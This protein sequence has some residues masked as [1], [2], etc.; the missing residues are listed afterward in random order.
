MNIAPQPDAATPAT[1]ARGDRA[2]PLIAALVLAAVACQLCIS[3]PTPAL[4]DIAA[5]L[6]TTTDVIGLA[7]ALFFLLGGLLSVIMAACSDYGNARTLMAVSLVLAVAGSLVAAA[8][9]GV[10]V[11]VVGRALQATA[12][13]VFPVALRVL[14]QTL[15]PGLFGRAMGIITAANGGIVGLD[16]L[17]SGWLTDTYGYRSVFLVMAG[18]GAV[19]TVVVLR[20]V[21]DLRQRP[22][23]RLDWAG[24]VV[25]SLGLACVELGIGM[26]GRAHAGVTLGTV[27]AGVVLFAVF[28]R[29]ESGRAHALLPPSYLKSRQAWPVLVTSV[30]ACAGML[31][32]VNYVVPVFSRSADA[33]YGLSATFAALLFIVP[34]C[35]VNVVFAPV[36]GA[37]APRVGW[38]RMLR[39]SMAVTV[40][41]LV[42]LGLGLG[43]RWVTFT[44]VVLVGF[45]LA[46]A[47]TPLNGLSAILAAPNN[48]GLLP[49][50]NAAAYGV[51]SSLGIAMASQLLGDR[52]GAADYHHAVWVAAGVVALGFLSSLLITG[53]AGEHGEKV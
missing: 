2:T 34:V 51:G 30:L 24:L 8:A 1:A 27:A 52:A 22:A 15:P 47:L 29:V 18:F 38:R 32:T 12:T 35:L 16:G 21:P 39:L 9:P 46:G 36:A 23:G 7:Q 25:L 13:A 45:G 20:V 6:H 3:M 44:L 42:C 41:V 40:P 26:A 14:R 17:L 53:R 5:T 33:G 43:S 11:F 4:P 50:V 19:T 31:S 37:L 48:P 49:G 28:W 10:A